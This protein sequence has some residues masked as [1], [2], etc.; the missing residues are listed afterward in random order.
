MSSLA[1]EA[2]TPKTRENIT[3]LM[4]QG[5]EHRKTRILEES[6]MAVGGEGAGLWALRKTTIWL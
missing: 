4:A 1:I 5:L 3:F 6:R 2:I